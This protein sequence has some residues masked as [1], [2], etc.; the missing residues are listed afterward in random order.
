MKARLPRKAIF[1]S[2][3][4]AC[5]PLAAA[6][7]DKPLPEAYSAVAIGTGGT[8]AGK[9][10]QFDVRITSYTTD[11]EVQKFAELVKA[12]GQNALVSALDKEDKG[13]VQPVA[14]TGNEIAVARKR[15]VDGITTITVVTTRLM[16]FR[17]LYNNSR[18]RDYPFGFIQLKLNAQGEG[19]G[20]IMAAA[21]IKFDKKQGQYVIESY[22]NQY[23]KV[24]NVRISK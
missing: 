9:S 11:D 21:K 5:L 3:L 18:S 19:T 23:I 20:E 14:S 1:L 7:Q 8:F 6:A 12:S 17:E 2:V 22:G 10:V 16:A 15:T 13:H 24:S 4:L